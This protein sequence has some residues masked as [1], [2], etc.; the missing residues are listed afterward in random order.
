[1]NTISYEYIMCDNNNII[2]NG[3]CFIPLNTILR[4]YLIDNTISIVTT[5]GCFVIEFPNYSRKVLTE[6]NFIRH[7]TPSIYHKICQ[8]PSAPFILR[9]IKSKPQ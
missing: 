2:I 1:M 4:V 8:A 3:T 5:R 6:F 7:H 9:L